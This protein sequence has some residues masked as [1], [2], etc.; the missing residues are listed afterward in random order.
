MIPR[1]IAIKSPTTV[2]F[3]SSETRSFR[4]DITRQRDQ[5]GKLALSNVMIPRDITLKSPPAVGG[6]PSQHQNF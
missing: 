6:D 3:G 2:E 5:P 1:D 4:I